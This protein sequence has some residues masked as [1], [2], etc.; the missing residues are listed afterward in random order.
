MIGV[1]KGPGEVVTAADLEASGMDARGDLVA[2]NTGWH[3]RYCGPATDP[4]R[5]RAYMEEAPGLCEESARWLVERGVKTVL[6]DTPA[7]DACIHMPY[8]E[9]RSRRTRC[10]SRRTSPASRGSAATSTS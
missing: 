3:H 6:V 2:V 8:G 9:A 5:A 7:L 1:P 10:C 4:I